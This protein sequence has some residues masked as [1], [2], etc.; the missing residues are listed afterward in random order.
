MDFFALFKYVFCTV[1]DHLYFNIKNKRQLL[2]I[3]THFQGSIGWETFMKVIIFPVLNCIFPVP[4]ISS[5]EKKRKKVGGRL[6]F[7]NA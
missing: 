2:V 7:V 6:N 3:H 1:Q 5:Q 4:G